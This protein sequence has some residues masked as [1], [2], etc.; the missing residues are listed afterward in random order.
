MKHQSGGDSSSFTDSKSNHSGFYGQL[1]STYAFLLEPILEVE[2]I[3]GTRTSADV[4]TGC[5][6]FILRDKC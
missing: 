6:D 3:Q 1:S 4:A 2:D 5:G